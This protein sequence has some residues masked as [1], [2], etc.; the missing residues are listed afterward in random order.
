MQQTT[1]NESAIGV[2]GPLCSV[3]GD[4]STGI[5][6]GGNSCES[7]KAFFRRSV[8]CLRYQ[9]Y[10]CSSDE[11]C[12]VNIVTRKVCQFCRYTKCTAIGMKPKWVLSDQ[13]REE[14]YGSRRKRFRE[15]R[16]TDED[17]E[18]LKYITKEEKLLIEDIAHALYQ[19]RAT[20]PLT[21]PN[22]ES[23]KT[24]VQTCSNENVQ[25]PPPSQQ[26]KP[27]NPAANFTIVPIQRL[28]LFAR[29]LKDFDQFSEDDKVSLLKG[30]AIEIIVC[31]ANTLFDPKTSTFTNYLSRDQHTVVD[32][33]IF[34][35]DPILLKI[36]GADVFNR[37]KTF[38]TS[39]CS[40][41]IDEI[42]STLLVPVMLFSPDRLGIQELDLVKRLQ[43]KYALLLKKYMCWRY[44]VEQTE[45]IYPKLLLQMVNLRE[46]SLSH[47][48]IIQSFM[49][50]SSVNPL[51]QEVIIK[52]EMF[53][54][55]V[56]DSPSFSPDNDTMD[57]DKTPSNDNESLFGSDEEDFT[58]RK[59]YSSVDDD[60]DFDFD[61]FDESNPK[62]IWRKKRK[63]TDHNQFPLNFQTPVNE[64][65]IT[66]TATNDFLNPQ[67]NSQQIRPYDHQVPTPL[68]LQYD[69]LG[70]LSNGGLSPLNQFGQIPTTTQGFVPSPQSIQQLQELYRA[71]HSTTT[72]DRSSFDSPLRQYST[73]S[74]T[75]SPVD[76]N[77][78][79]E[80]NYLS[81]PSNL[82]QQ[83]QQQNEQQFTQTI[84]PSQTSTNPQSQQTTNPSE[85]FNQNN[86]EQQLL[87]AIHAHPNKRDLV[88]S[89]L[90]QMDQPDSSLS[91]KHQSDPSTN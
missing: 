89:L 69:D 28:V 82:Q 61:D 16:A 84:S 1:M 62:N 23:F 17:P 12:P 7:C 46:L 14:K 45:I 75:M 60:L 30:S 74:S 42:T 5:H 68:T 88:L 57:F 87:N 40:L 73:Y 18:I 66:T 81:S 50:S 35:L 80:H 49:A 13:E 32:N 10:K 56:P 4:I 59:N 86:A 79:D 54:K 90:R 33:Q 29:K 27:P 65:T 34:S 19:T 31:S 26:E 24:V 25:T 20:Y 43:E 91:Y 48:E 36:W 3:C 71:H 22:P 83:P 64:L 77:F 41:N 51:V 58:K 85:D 72:N 2:P 63:Y 44:G 6:F 78:F 38:L 15:N 55:P 67:L 8:Q 53:R 76:I 70:F 21:F 39:M 9:N 47:A 37:T 11:R 52:P